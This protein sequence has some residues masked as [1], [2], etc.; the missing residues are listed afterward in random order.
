MRTVSTIPMAF[1]LNAGLIGVS[2]AK[3]IFSCQ[4]QND[5]EG[6]YFREY[7]VDDGTWEKSGVM[8]SSRSQKPFSQIEFQLDGQ[9]YALADG[10]GR[11]SWTGHCVRVDQ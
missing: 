5:P 8:Y 3:S 1:M 2:E 9:H 4:F 11:I 10:K 6:L 7:D